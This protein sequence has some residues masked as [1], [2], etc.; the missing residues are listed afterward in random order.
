[1]AAGVH[2]VDL[3]G[4][5]ASQPFPNHAPTV[6]PPKSPFESPSSH[7]AQAEILRTHSLPGFVEGG[8][9]QAATD[10]PSDPRLAG[11]TP[12]TPTA[13]T[14]PTPVS[15]VA[16]A[17][18]AEGVTDDF[19][20]SIDTDSEDSGGPGSIEEDLIMAQRGIQH[21]DSNRLLTA[22]KET[23]TQI[24]ER[25]LIHMPPERHGEAD[26]LVKY[27]EGLRCK[28]LTTRNAGTWDLFRKNFGNLCLLVVHPTEDYYETLPGLSSFVMNNGSGAQVFSIGVQY[29]QCLRE[30]RASEYGACRLFPHGGMNFIT[31][32]VFVYY[33]EKALEIIEKFLEN[34]KN[35]PP[36]GETSKIGARPGIKQWLSDLAREDC[37]KQ[38]K[39]IECHLALCRLCPFEDEEPDIH[40]E[41]RGVPSERSHLWSLSPD[42]LKSFKGRW[43][44]GDEEGATD[45][46]ANLFAG[47]AIEMAWK[48]RKFVFVYQRPDE[49]ESVLSSQGQ[50][51]IQTKADPKGWMK[52]YNQ[53][54]VMTPDALLNQ[55]R[56]TK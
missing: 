24:I 22:W 44:S 55:G 39:W 9:N 11:R 1:M 32:D 45:Y 37:E 52:K 46:M 35:K 43:E 21:L 36:G 33:P 16:P 53:I 13:G 31:D 2:T 18:A 20:A 30:D 6:M 42:T 28:V 41:L 7:I 27:F 3:P 29:Q 8:Y 15:P 23:G 34:T 4:S 17:Q 19:S 50:Q 48:F 49:M 38:A 25:V 5:A 14:A 12:R 54:S 10:R 40:N 26:L 56:K 47:T 51:S